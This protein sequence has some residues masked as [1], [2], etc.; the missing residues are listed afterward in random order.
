MKRHPA[1]VFLAA[2]VANAQTVTVGNSSG[3]CGQAVSVPVTIDSVSG[4]LSLELRIA[5]DAARVTPGAVTAGALTSGFSL[6][7]NATGGVLHVAM[8]SGTP[9]SGG[10]TV[11][12][13]MFTAIADAT[14]SVPLTISNVLVND[15]ARAGNPGA[16]SLTCVHLPGIPMLISP[17]NGATGIAP[18]VTLQWNAAADATSYRL[19]F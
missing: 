4:M 2:A 12:N 11:A 15:A 6:S 5:Y 17:A 3:Q 10:G 8:A 14:G 1:L 16:L 7:S 19:Y 18:P 9:V 13:V